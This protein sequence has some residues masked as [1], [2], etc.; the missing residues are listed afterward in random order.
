M[1]KWIIHIFFI[2]VGV[3]FTGCSHIVPAQVKKMP[4]IKVL[5]DEHIESISLEKYV[6]S[7]LAGEVGH[8]WPLESLKAQA[9]AARTFAILRMRER[10]AS[11]YHVQ[12]SQ[13]DQVLKSKPAE[14]FITAARETAGLVLTLDGRLAETS[15]H[16]TCGGNT[17]NAKSVWGRNYPHLRGV[18]CGYCKSSPTFKWETELELSDLEAKFK[19]KINA[20]KILSRSKDG[21]VD[22]LELVGDKNQKINGH[23]FRMTMGSMKIKSTLIKDIVIDGTKVRMHGGGFGHGVGM[24]QIGAY[25]MGRANKSFQEILSR[26]YPKTEIKRLY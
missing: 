9:I 4:M 20:I 6:A 18:E 23:D 24:C 7:V 13:I 10:K 19:Q 21:R 14:V 11:E 12:N 16:S 1:G 15:Y 26:Y 17:T 25:G 22:K 2:V 5:H 3:I 8:S